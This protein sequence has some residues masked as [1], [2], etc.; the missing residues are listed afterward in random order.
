M[1]RVDEDI[2][3][4]VN[5][6][7]TEAGVDVRNLAIEVDSGSVTIAG[8]VPDGEQQHR[9]QALARFIQPAFNEVSCRVDVVAVP[10]TDAAD[11]RGRSPLTGT[12][13]DSAHESRHQRDVD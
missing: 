12:S 10:P 11:G 8:S 4:L 13:S 1:N 6:G 7:L 2:R 3:G 5:D 9:V